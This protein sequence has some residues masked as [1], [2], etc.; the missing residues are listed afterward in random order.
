MKRKNYKGEGDGKGILLIER[1]K[2]L[3]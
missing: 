3:T 2:Q 1:T